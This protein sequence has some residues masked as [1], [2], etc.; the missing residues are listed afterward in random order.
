M[1]T[2][3][4]MIA[5]LKEKGYELSATGEIKV[6]ENPAVGVRVAA[7]GQK[8]ITLYF[9]KKTNLLAKIDHTAIDAMSGNEVPEERIVLAYEKNADG[10]PVP[11]KVAVKRD[12]KT[13]L[14]ADVLESKQLE[15]IDDSEFVK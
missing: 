14:E 10:V 15:K 7:K 3:A 2:V 9:D 12:G 4:R 8:D 11:K 13:Y 5:P 1:M 6:G